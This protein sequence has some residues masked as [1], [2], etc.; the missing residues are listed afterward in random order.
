MKDYYIVNS[1]ALRFV[2]ER[3]LYCQ[4]QGTKVC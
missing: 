4:Q 3:L 2:D 1:K